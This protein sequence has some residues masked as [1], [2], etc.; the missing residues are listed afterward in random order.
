M[1]NQVVHHHSQ[2]RRRFDRYP[3]GEGPRLEM[4]TQIRTRYERLQV[5]AKLVLLGSQ[6][7]G[8]LT[9]LGLTIRPA[10]HSVRHYSEVTAH[11]RSFLKP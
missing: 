7:Q 11:E 5:H 3:R 10:V 4:Q 9:G 2:H 8:R 1:H 6:S